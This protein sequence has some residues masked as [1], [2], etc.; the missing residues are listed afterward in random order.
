DYTLNWE[1]I[2][3]NKIAFFLSALLIRR[4]VAV[5]LGPLDEQLTTSE[6]FKYY[7]QLF[8]LGFENVR[9][10]PVCTYLYRNHKTSVTKNALGVYT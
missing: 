10:L 5:Q 4:S 1:A 6:D 3:A 9:V 2:C 7:I 8:Q